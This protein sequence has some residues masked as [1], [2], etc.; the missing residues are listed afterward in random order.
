[1]AELGWGV[2]GVALATIISQFI[3]SVLCIINQAHSARQCGNVSVIGYHQR[4]ITDSRSGAGVDGL[5]FVPILP[6]HLD[7]QGGDTGLIVDIVAGG[8]N[9]NGIHSGHLGGGSLESLQNVP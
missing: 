6:G 1:M 7:K 2:P 5:D 8:R 3:S 4:Y 9:A